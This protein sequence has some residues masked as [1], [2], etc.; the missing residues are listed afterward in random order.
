MNI[1]RKYIHRPATGP[2]SRRIRGALQQIVRRF[3]DQPV[4]GKEEGMRMAF[5][6]VA[7]SGPKGDYLEFGVY[8]GR[9]FILAYDYARRHGLSD[10]DFLAFD[11]FEGLSAPIGVESA[12]FVEGQ[13]A[14]ARDR[15]MQN[16]LAAKVA[17]SR[18][19]IISGYFSESLTGETHRVVGNRTAAIVWID[20]D[21]FEPTL[22]ALEFVRPLL[23]DG[24][25]I[26]FD[27]W[28]SFSGHPHAGEV[29]ASHEFL[30]RWPHISFIE[31][32]N[33]GASGKQFLVHIQPS[34][35]R[36]SATATGMN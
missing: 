36:L 14:Y 1:V 5:H 19:H 2:R 6:R 32:R 24:T 11:S 27:D 35:S 29:A 16:L 3:L 26:C 33:F 7:S 12:Q 18:V 31:Y 23:T 34:K 22:Q 10:M 9:S 30:R 8:R 28:Y 25:C 17:L 15:F 4:D 20:C 13:F 21:L